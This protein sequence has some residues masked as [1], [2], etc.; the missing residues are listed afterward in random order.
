MSRKLVFE[1][2]RFTQR[3]YVLLCGHTTFVQPIPA[4]PMTIV[5]KITIY[6]NHVNIVIFTIPGTPPSEIDKF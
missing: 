1:K 5:Y 6:S 2:N 4:L 3:S